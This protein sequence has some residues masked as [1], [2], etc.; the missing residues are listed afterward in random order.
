MTEKKL[1]EL[2]HY[3]TEEIHKLTTQLYEDLHTDKGE[4]EKDW[5]L[6]LENVRN[7]KKAV[8]MELESV[9]HALKEYKEDLDAK[10]LS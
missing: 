2:Y 1:S 6:T 5:P 8:I 3:A 10:Q 7:Y 9:K 4:P